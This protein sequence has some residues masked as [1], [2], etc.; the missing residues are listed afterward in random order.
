[1]RT[2]IRAPRRPVL[3]STLTA[4]VLIAGCTASPAPN[5]STVPGESTAPSAP[6]TSVPSS[7]VGSRSATPAGSDEAATFGVDPAVV[8]K[9]RGL[10]APGPGKTVQDLPDVAIPAL[11][12]EGMSVPEQRAGTKTVPALQVPAVERPATIAEAGC[13]VTYDAP[14]GCLPAVTISAGWIPGYR[15]EG[16]SFSRE[17]GDMVTVEPLEREATVAPEASIGQKCQVETSGKYVNAVY[18]SALYRGA[19]YQGAAYRRAMYRGA[20][21]SDGERVDPVAVPPR[22]VPPVALPPA[23]IP[24]ASLPGRQVTKEVSANEDDTVVAYTASD[25]VLF[26][27]NKS[28]LRRSA[29]KTLDAI[30]ADARAK[31]FAGKVRVDGH[32]DATGTNAYNQRLSEARARAVAAYLVSKGIAA[33]RIT[34][35]G[36]G[37]TAP[38][39]PND[40][41]KNRAKNRRVVIEFRQK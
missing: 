13:L 38:A 30:L 8:A 39:Y 27:Y 2:F 32:T 4:V 10:C 15:I 3:V 19:V 34:A 7:S 24:A 31:G 21:Y 9:V 6:S 1:M 12:W 26:E 14:A 40:S 35:T 18:R 29:A 25:A 37:E 16:Y 28:V 23:D 5:S 36:R 17:T 20:V 22:S 11:S 41:A 33:D